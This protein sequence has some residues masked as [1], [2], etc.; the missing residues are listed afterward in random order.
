MICLTWCFLS[1]L[2]QAA[3]PLFPVR[4]LTSPLL[5]PAAAM[6]HLQPSPGP[7]VPSGHL[8]AAPALAWF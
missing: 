2:L 5:T 1:W 8:E 4:L 3:A 7:R 6:R